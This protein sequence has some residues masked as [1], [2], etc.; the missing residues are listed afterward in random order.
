MMTSEILDVVLALSV[1]IVGG[2][3]DDAN[4]GTARAFTMC[5][6]IFHPHHHGRLQSNIA[7]SFNKNHR[8]VS[9]I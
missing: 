5:I 2:L 4:T 7:I 9:D 6:D 1:R 3:A 8:P